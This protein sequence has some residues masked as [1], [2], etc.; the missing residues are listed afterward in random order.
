MYVIFSIAAL[1]VGSTVLSKKLNKEYDVLLTQE[2]IEVT[3]R[4][5]RTIQFNL[6][7]LLMVNL[8]LS[9]CLGRNYELNWSIIIFI[10]VFGFASFMGFLT[11]KDYKDKNNYKLDFRKGSVICGNQLYH[12][13]SVEKLEYISNTRGNT[14]KHTFVL[15]IKFDNEKSIE[16]I[17]S[18]DEKQVLELCHYLRKALN[19]ITEKISPKGLVGT[20]TSIMN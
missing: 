12:L 4:P 13:Q 18:K 9:L 2:L 17:R 10:V 11:I 6:V 7:L 8:V 15:N 20:E 3:K 19:V 14:S 16:L 5:H 1:F